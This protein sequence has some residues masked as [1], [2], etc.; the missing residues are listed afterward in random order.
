MWLNFIYRFTFSVMKNVLFMSPTL[1]MGGAQQHMVYFANYLI[2]RNYK[3]LVINL[4]LDNTIAYRFDG[5]VE[6][7]NIPRAYNFDLKPAKNVARIVKERKIE[8]IFCDS[9]ICYLFLFRLHR[10]KSIK[11]S[12]IFHTSF[13]VSRYFYLKDFFVRLLV[14]KGVRLIGIAENQIEFL[15]RILF[16]KKNR[17]RLIYNG[18][19]TN[20]F[21]FEYRVNSRADDMRRQLS[22]PDNAFVIVKTARFSPEKNH[23]M[24]IQVLALLRQKFKIDAYMI[25]V[26]NTNR[27]RMELIGTMSEKFA[28]AE[29]VRMVGVARD[30]RPY[31]AIS[32]LF[33][34]TSK[35]VETFSIAALEAMSVGLPVVITDLGGAREMVINGKNG[36]VVDCGDAEKFSQAV[37]DIVKG[38]LEFSNSDISD[39]IS[40]NFGL[41]NTNRLLEE[42]IF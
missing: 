10:I 37:V 32:D 28:V 7:I 19:D 16:F 11:I 1:G 22:I 20:I 5:G 13:Y 12:I 30:V 4:S 14:R 41:D 34:L 35:S 18:V 26:G 31:L 39:F 15:S 3:V 38:N 6:I 8:T 27:N 9:L 33:I 23:E 21:N 25:F 40:Q 24:A 2:S 36:F 17:F 42:F 29:Y